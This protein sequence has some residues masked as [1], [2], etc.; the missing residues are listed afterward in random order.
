MN[1]LDGVDPV[2]NRPSTEK[3]QKMQILLYIYSIVLLS[4]KR[5]CCCYS[6]RH[7]EQSLTRNIRSAQNRGHGSHSCWMSW[8]NLDK[9]SLFQPS[10]AS[11]RESKNCWSGCDFHGSS[12]AIPETSSCVF[13]MQHILLTK[14]LLQAQSY[15][16]WEITAKKKSWN[17]LKDNIY[18]LRIL[19]H[20]YQNLLC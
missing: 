6:N 5:I 18:F 1:K 19:C 17:I 15:S 16:W 14:G 11:T 4:V 2:D 10:L 20:I 8:Q 7:L 9:G 12:A 13:V 3:L